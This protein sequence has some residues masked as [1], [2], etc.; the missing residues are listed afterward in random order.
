MP[1]KTE[2]TTPV[3]KKIVVAGDMS[4]DW[5]EVLAS[6]E[7][8]ESGELLECQNWQGHPRVSRMVKMGGAPLLAEFILDKVQVITV[9]GVGAIF[10]GPA[11]LSTNM[12]LPRSH[13]EVQAAMA[14]VTIELSEPQPI[15]Q[16]DGPDWGFAQAITAGLQLAAN[17]VKALIVVVL[18]ALPLAAIAL[19]VFLVIRAI[20]RSRRRRSAA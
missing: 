17:V 6:P 5:F 20:V 16:P 8:L 18:G 11:D 14:T 9:P 10:I 7:T 2:K 3:K 12:G 1:N 13:P 15:V 19:V 4:F